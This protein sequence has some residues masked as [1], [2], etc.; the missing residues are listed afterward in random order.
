MLA[1]FGAFTSTSVFMVIT[2]FISVFFI[3]SFTNTS[4]LVEEVRSSVGET[5]LLDRD[6][7]AEE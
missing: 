5:V 1:E 6:S 2:A 4:Y 7:A 3:D